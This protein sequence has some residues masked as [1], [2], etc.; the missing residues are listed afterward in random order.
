M[1][2][3]RALRLPRSVF[4]FV[5][6]DPPDLPPSVALDENTHSS[7]PFA[8]DPYGCRDLALRRKRAGRNPF[9]RSLSYPHGCAKLAPLI[10]RC[11][12][13]LFGGVLPWSRTPADAT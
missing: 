10:E 7:H 1:L 9:R 3:R 11:P 12:P 13:S 6:I 5:G 8:T 4:H 2:H